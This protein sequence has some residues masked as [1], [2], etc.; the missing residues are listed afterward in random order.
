MAKT[1]TWN[2][3]FVSGVVNG[4]PAAVQRAIDLGLPV[5]DYV[6]CDKTYTPLHLAVERR[7]TPAVVAVLLT[8]GADVNSRTPGT[9]ETAVEPGQTPLMIAA[10]SGRLDLVKQLLAAGATVHLKNGYG[11]SALAYA[12][13]GGKTTANENVLKELLAT[14]AKPDAE[15]LTA[16]ARNGSPAMVRLVVAAGSDIH[17]VSRF[18]TALHLAVDEKRV[19]TVEALLALGADASFRLP[20]TA[21]VYGGKTALDLAREAKLKKLLPLLEGAAAGNTPPPKP[22]VAPV[23]PATISDL[24]KR[25]EKALKTTAV[26][27]SLKKGATDKKLAALESALGVE[28]PAGVRESYLLHDGQKDG[29]D[30]LLPEGFAD[31]DAEYVL[32]SVAG[33]LDDWKSWKK[34]LDS[35]EFDGQTATPDAGVRADWWNPGWVPIASNGG[36]DSVCIDLNPAKGGTLGQVILMNHESSHRLR[37]AA[38]FGEL[39]ARLAEHYEEQAKAE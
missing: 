4:D 28:L 38:S 26:K 16:A 31:L 35:G 33:I 6:F 10:K 32:L 2:D 25:L 9:P 19:D 1:S 23:A 34:L 12:C 27:K 13:W 15:V 30:G 22:L 5:K 24:W 18:G 29:A 7:A 21:R 37:L 3:E 36:G 8:A 17:E 14:G 11:I 39:L 20:T